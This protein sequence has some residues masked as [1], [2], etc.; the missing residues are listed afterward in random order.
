[1]SRKEFFNK[2]LWLI[3]DWEGQELGVRRS[4]YEAHTLCYKYTEDE[5]TDEWESY[6]PFQKKH[7]EEMNEFENSEWLYTCLG[8]FTFTGHE[9]FT[10]YNFLEKIGYRPKSILDFHSVIGLHT[11]LLAK[12]YPGIQLT[13]FHPTHRTFEFARDCL[14]PE[15]NI[16]A[17][18]IADVNQIPKA[19]LVCSYEVFERDPEPIPLLDK[20]LDTV[21]MFLS[22]SNCWTRPARTHF[23]EYKIGNEWVNKNQVTRKY[24]EYVQ[25]R[26]IRIARGWNSRPL[27]FTP[28]EKW[29]IPNG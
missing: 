8:S 6:S 20:A 17:N 29:L 22:M 3:I 16:Q 24:N 9:V 10:T 12:L 23:E 28:K 26:M 21:G 19:D 2:L 15:F 25:K 1:M 5:V 18:I 14:F 13:Y 4:V 11:L 7:L 27:I